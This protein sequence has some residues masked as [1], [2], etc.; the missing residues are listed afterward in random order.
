MNFESFIHN[1]GFAHLEIGNVAMILIGIIFIFLAVV[2]NVTD[3]LAPFERTFKFLS[4]FF[5]TTALASIGFT[6]DFDAIIEQGVK[7]L[8]VIILSWSII[9]ISIFI[10]LGLF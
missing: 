7:P 5:L 10:I 8:A 3:I 4:S 9:V 6:V 1:T 2:V